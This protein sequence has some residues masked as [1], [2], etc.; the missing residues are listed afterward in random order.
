MPYEYRKLSLPEREEL[1]R[2]RGERGYPLHAP[3]HPFREA[4][5]YLITAAI[6]EHAPVMNSPERRTEFEKLLMDAMKE[7]QAE[8]IC[9]VVLPTHYHT[10]LNG[11]LETVTWDDVSPVEPRGRP[12]REAPGLV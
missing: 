5:Y 2:Y 4:G 11:D 6:F 1:V 7:I 12:H 8:M 3:P 10:L 9:W